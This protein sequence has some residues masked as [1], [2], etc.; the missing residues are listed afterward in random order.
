MKTICVI[1]ARMGSS[2]FPGKPIE[3]ILGLELVLHVYNRCRLAGGLDRI[4]VATCDEEI[5]DVCEGH[6]VEVVMTSDVH[7]GCVDRTEE[8]ID[9]VGGDLANDDLVLMVQGDEIMIAPG[10][11][12]NILKA[13]AESKAPVVNLASPIMLTSDHDDPNVVKVVTALDGRALFF[14]RTP[15]PSPSRASNR[16]VPM[17]QQTGV[18]GFSKEFLHTFGKLTRSPLEEIE[19]ID[20]LRTLEHNYPIQIVTTASETIGVDTPADRD[21][22]EDML[23]DDPVTSSYL[24]T[25][26]TK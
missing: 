14:S 6:G 2:R 23:L 16:A 26:P 24:D 8:T 7:P 5:Q 25:A 20:M 1:P 9:K 15:I 18:I 12:E 21:R 13:Y 4:V 3:K 10:M 19:C 22:A 11:I 17:L